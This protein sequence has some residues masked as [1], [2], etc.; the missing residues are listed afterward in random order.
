MAANLLR[1][2]TICTVANALSAAMPFLLLP[3]LTPTLAPEE[4]SGAVGLGIVA[5]YLDS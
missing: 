1:A 5:R 2:G 3:I 4:E